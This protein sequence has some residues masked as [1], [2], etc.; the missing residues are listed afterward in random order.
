MPFLSKRSL[1]SIAPF[2]IVPCVGFLQGCAPVIIGSGVAVSVATG[3]YVMTRDKTV[4]TSIDDTKIGT[5]IRSN[6]YRISPQ[7][8]S[9]VSVMVDK[10]GV[11]LT[12]S[13]SEEAWIERVEEEAW[14]VKGVI[15]V[16]NN[17]VYGKK[18]S[19]ATIMKDSLITSEVRTALLGT[20]EVRSS[21]YKIKTTDGIVYL[22]GIA[23]T[24][25][26]RKIAL[27]TI[28]RIKG[29]KKIVSYV[30]IKQ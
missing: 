11:L 9:D 3:G 7:C 8:Y 20:K 29:V 2:L 4:G 28:R 15:S 10:G 19:V 14:K 13:V 24:E 22:R 17:L 1:R 26:E 12:G 18:I 5:V 27:D 25:R 16:D 6:L 23:Y 30:T 21:N